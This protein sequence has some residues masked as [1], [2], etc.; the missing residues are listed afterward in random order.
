MKRRTF[1]VM[2]ATALVL[3]LLAGGYIY[4]AAISR[5]DLNKILF[6]KL[7]LAVIIG[8]IGVT[9]KRWIDD[10]NTK[11]K[12]FVDQQTSS[13]NQLR[14]SASKLYVFAGKWAYEFFSD[15][16]DKKKM[17]KLLREFEQQ[18]DEYA[19]MMSMAKPFVSP[20]FS[21]AAD[22]YYWLIYDLSIFGRLPISPSMDRWDCLDF[23][24]E[25]FTSLEA[26]FVRLLDVSASPAPAIGLAKIA[27]SDR[28]F[29]QQAKMWLATRCATEPAS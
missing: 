22:T 15:N 12:F 13:S 26:E 21:A 6:E 14:V 27:T 4:W 9:L 2:M 16:R 18:L 29:E 23:L 11:R 24:Q 3:A 28:R 19:N 10:W 8:S 7:L 17:E 5:A 20:Q 25:L 1:E